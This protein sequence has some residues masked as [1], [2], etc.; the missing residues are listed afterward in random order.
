MQEA[1]R[2]QAFNDMIPTKYTVKIN[3]IFLEERENNGA[4]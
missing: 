1:A 2:C 3:L 4:Y